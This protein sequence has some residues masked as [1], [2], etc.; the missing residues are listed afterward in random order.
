MIGVKKPPI[1]PEPVSK[2]ENSKEEQRTTSVGVQTDL[3]ASMISNMQH[4]LDKLRQE[5][6][7]LEQ[8]V[9]ENSFD[10][11]SFKDDEKT[12]YYTGLSNLSLLISLFNFLQVYL[13]SSSKLTKFQQLL[14]V[15]MRLRLGCQIQDLAYRFNVLK[16]HIS[17]NFFSDFRYFKY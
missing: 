11:K 4:E 12:K 17:K 13:P 14:F 1:P 3:S 9:E 6:K 8:E 15:L 16:P 10:L 5:K 7:K 2:D